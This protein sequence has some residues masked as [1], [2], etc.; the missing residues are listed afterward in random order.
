MIQSFRDAAT[1][2]V[3]DGKCAKGFPNEIIKTARRKLREIHAAGSLEDPRRIPGNRL[4][5]LEQERSGQ[6]AISINDRWR[7]CFVWQDGNA[8]EVEITDYHEQGKNHDREEA[9]AAPPG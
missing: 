7:V 3:F 6:H 2:K 9:A 1:R 5:R 8:H 4:H